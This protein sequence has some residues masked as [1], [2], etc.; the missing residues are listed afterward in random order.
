ML[1]E[2]GNPKDI[3]SKLGYALINDDSE[4][5]KFVNEVLDANP[6]S[7]VDFKGGKDRA[8]GFLVGQ[9]MKASHGKVN[10]ALTSKILMEELK[11]R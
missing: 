5:V 10:P 9:V 4:I 3:A 6:Q 8:F 7:I 1:S 11:R 2:G